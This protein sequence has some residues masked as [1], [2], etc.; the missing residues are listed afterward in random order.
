MSTV[1]ENE[2]LR[3]EIKERGAELS[4][5]KNRGGY[6]YI[7]QGDEKI[8]AKQCPVLFPVCGRLVNKKY[9]YGGNTYEMNSH[10]FASAS[11]FRAERL[12]ETAALFTLTE[13]EETLAQYPFCFVFSVKYELVG[14]EL[15]VE[16]A[17]KNADDKDL[18]FSFGAH[19]AYN[20]RD[21]DRW[22]VEFERQE[23]LYVKK[24]ASLGYLGEGR[25][26]FRAGVKE[27]PLNYELF[28][29]DALI[30]DGLRSRF[31][32][33]KRE[34]RSVV[35][36]DFHGF[37]ELLLWTKAGAPYLCIEPWNGLPDYADTDG[38]FTRKK[39]IRKLAA[40]ETFSSVH[41]IGF[42]E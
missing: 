6:E 36:V 17:V 1:I 34:G 26:L 10:G 2:F 18:Y 30:F 21:F 31:V 27:L 38:E 14:R 7:W 12:S 29:N 16:Y 40:G 41:R 8:W 33:L 42:C 28:L 22:S 9:R 15:V 4:S 3:A 32:T 35:T 5:V 37:D 11:V 24:Q 25:E 39:G 20:V 19:E 13:N 23:D